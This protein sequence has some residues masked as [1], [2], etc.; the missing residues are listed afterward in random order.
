M[1]IRTIKGYKLNSST[2]STVH[3]D[4]DKYGY[5]VHVF[6]LSINYKNINAHVYYTYVKNMN[7]FYT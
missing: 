3:L 4:I 6:Q 2:L 7:N 1:Q 5:A